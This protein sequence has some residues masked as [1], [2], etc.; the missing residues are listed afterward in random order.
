MKYSIDKEQEKNKGKGYSKNNLEKNLENSNNNLNFNHLT[1]NSQKNKK[2]NDGI[3]NNSIYINQ[4]NISQNIQNS[5]SN[6]NVNNSSNSNNS[7]I[8]FNNS[9]N[10]NKSNKPNQLFRPLSDSRLFE[11]ANQYI[12][13]DESLEKFQARLKNKYSSIHTHNNVN[14]NNY[15]SNLDV[16][17]ERIPSKGNKNILIDNSYVNKKESSKNKKNDRL[18]K[19]IISS[20]DY[21]KMIES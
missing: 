6:K 3:P 9:I 11:M 7:K 17:E 1:N 2:N 19:N 21:Y 13:T 16:I 18:T 8:S 4:N 15:N 20:L 12:T 10:K 5:S 14:I